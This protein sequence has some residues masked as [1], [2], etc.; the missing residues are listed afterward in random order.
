MAKITVR[1]NHQIQNL[2][3]LYVRLNAEPNIQV[4]AL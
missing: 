1:N 2:T 4:L 3:S